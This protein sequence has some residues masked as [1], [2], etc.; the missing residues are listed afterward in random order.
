MVTGETGGTASIDAVVA[1]AFA[2]WCPTYAWG[3]V[4]CDGEKPCQIQPMHEQE[5]SEPCRICGVGRSQ[6]PV[7]ELLG[8]YVDVCIY[9]LT[10]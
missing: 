1:P 4:L 6:V 9:L 8:M 2:Q 10:I 7:C 5:T 3:F